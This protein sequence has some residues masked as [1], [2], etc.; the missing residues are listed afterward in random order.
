[1]AISSKL[2]KGGTKQPMKQS[3]GKKRKSF[4]M[5]KIFKKTMQKVHQFLSTLISWLR[6]P[7]SQPRS[8]SMSS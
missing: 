1:M 4:V 8:L 7:T 3:V 5:P 6:S 2:A